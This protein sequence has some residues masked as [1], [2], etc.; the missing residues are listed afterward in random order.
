M[1]ATVHYDHSMV[2]RQR[3]YLVSPIVSVCQAAMEQDHRPALTI[4]GIVDTDPV[5]LG[6][7]ATLGVDRRRRGWQRLPALGSTGG[8]RDSTRIRNR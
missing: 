8:Q 5:G 4:D 3:L 7:A 2:G 1:A 6:L